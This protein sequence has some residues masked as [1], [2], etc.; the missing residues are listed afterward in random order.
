MLVTTTLGRSQFGRP[1]F[2]DDTAPTP[3][4][5]ARLPLL[6]N[7]ALALA[8]QENELRKTFAQLLPDLTA[9]QTVNQTIPDALLTLLQS[10]NVAQATFMEAAQVWLQARAN[11]PASSLPDPNAQAIAV[12]TF[13]L[14]A[15][16][17][18][19]SG[20]GFAGIPA[21]HIQIRYGI[22]GQEVST[23]LGSFVANYGY[24]GF[25]GG[26]GEFGALPA[27]FVWLVLLGLAILGATVVL[28]ARTLSTSDT[29]AA[30]NA[31]TAQARGRIQEVQSD[32]D[33][34]VSTRDTCIGGS[35]DIEVRRQ[36]IASAAS[37]LK[38]AKEGRP[39][40]IKPISSTAVGFITVVGVL[41]VLGVAGGIGYAIHKRKQRDGGDDFPRATAHR[42]SGRRR[43][44]RDDDYDYD[45]TD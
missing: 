11:T 36:C 19:S 7:S 2:G 44:S 29:A 3:A 40:A 8:A 28:V 18:P 32:R 9:L 41:G 37:V 4:E 34:F 42:S 35:Q 31:I 22:V 23:P 25:G 1:Q 39:V 6:T 20:F 16:S 38:M 13:D 14:G 26:L 21:S 15:N 12:P 24:S 27:G 5:E 43:P 17:T 33:L 45:E 10:Y 30:N